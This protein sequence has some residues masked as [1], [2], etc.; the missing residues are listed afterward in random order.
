[1]SSGRQYSHIHTC[2]NLIHTHCYKEINKI[3]RLLLT[4]TYVGLA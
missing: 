4:C 3:I 1:V 2:T